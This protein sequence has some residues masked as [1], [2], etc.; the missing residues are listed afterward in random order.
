MLD[1]C[2]RFRLRFT[3]SAHIEFISSATVLYYRFVVVMIW[4]NYEDITLAIAHV[5]IRLDY[6]SCIH[7]WT[8]SCVKISSEVCTHISVWTSVPFVV[9]SFP[10][11]I[12]KNYYPKLAQYHIR[13]MICVQSRMADVLH[14]RK[15]NRMKCC[16]WHTNNLRF[17]FIKLTC[18]TVK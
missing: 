1:I 4:R 2:I 3:L 18:L 10:K 16:K 17:L 5:S 13:N 15:T 14:M 9:V 7:L 6:L 12:N 8:H 11:K